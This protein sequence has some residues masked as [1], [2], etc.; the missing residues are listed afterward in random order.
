MKPIVVV[1]YFLLVISLLIFSQ[2]LVQAQSSTVRLNSLMVELWLEYDHPEV[3]V[4]YRGQLSPDTALP[5]TVAFPIPAYVDEMHAVAIEDNGE[6]FNVNP[7]TIELGSQDDTRLL[8]FQVT[9]P[10]FQFEYYD[11]EI[12]TRQDQLRRLDYTFITAHPI[13][14]LVLEVQEPVQAQDFLMTPE[15]ERSFVA[16]NTLPHH[17]VRR[18]N[19]DPGQTVG[20][21]ASYSRATDA[22][23]VGSVP[24]GPPEEPLNIAVI[25]GTPISENLNIGYILLGAGLL[26]L[27]GTGGYWWWS[28][29]SGTE[30]EAR[31][32]GAAGAPPGRLRKKKNN[33]QPARRVVEV[34]SPRS[35]AASVPGGG[36]C[37]RCGTALRPDAEFCHACGAQRRRD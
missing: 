21:S 14:T 11:P 7:D 37:Y 29:R 33:G 30:L 19:L 20:L 18:S 10:G 23:S 6:L 22:P 36:Y 1:R 5:A 12:L 25:S 31:P 28:K 3:L 24:S 27:L 15:P 35:P 34:Q 4:I 13:D 8:S 16:Q 17:T 9:A 32:L 2:Q 26:L